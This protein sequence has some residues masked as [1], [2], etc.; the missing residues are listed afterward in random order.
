MT[1][2]IPNPLLAFI[3]LALIPLSPLFSVHHGIIVTFTGEA[4]TFTIGL[5]LILCAAW[6]RPPTYTHGI[7]Y[8]SLFAL[9]MVVLYGVQAVSLPFF[10]PSQYLIPMILFA[11]VGLACLGVE[12]LKAC[13]DPDK[14][15][16][17]LAIGLVIALCA[18]I[19]LGYMQ[20]FKLG[21][22]GGL[23][24]WINM[25]GV[26]GAF[27]Q[28]NQ[29]GNFM[30]CGCVALAYLYAT[31]KIN[32]ANFIGVVLLAAF[33]MAACQSRS[34]GLY[35]LAL[36]TYLAFLAFLW[37][38]KRNTSNKRFFTAI[39]AL[40]A[41]QVI[42]QLSYP[43]LNQKVVKPYILG[44]KPVATAMQSSKARAKPK[45]A[46]ARLTDPS[47]NAR[48]L[49]EWKK[50][51]L[52]FQQNPIIGAGAQ[53]NQQYSFFLQA[54]PQFSKVVEESLF[55]HSHNLFTQML[56]ETGLVGTGIILAWILFCLYQLAK[57]HATPRK[58]LAMG[59]L[60]V[61]LCHSMVEFPL[62]YAYFFGLL[63]ITTSLAIDKPI[64][65]PAPPKI[66]RLLL[67][68]LGVAGIGLLTISAIVMVVLSNMPSSTGGKNPAQDQQNLA[69][70]NRI[71]E[72]PLYT[73]YADAAR[74]SYITRDANLPI[75]LK[76][77]YLEQVT[78]FAAYGS[79]V[80]D[81]TRHLV[82]GQQTEKAIRMAKAWRGAYPRQA[83]RGLCAYYQEDNPLFATVAQGA[84]VEAQDC[85]A[86]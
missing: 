66:S 80:S 17:A 20:W 62:W 43:V 44:Q 78:Y 83:K 45:A 8:P 15:M 54:Q 37:L 60:L 35:I 47:A 55:T 56:S 86:R 41:L 32:L 38:F 79:R 48:R 1:N 85:E 26:F 65:L 21:H 3:L 7:P 28:K 14:L 29:Y 34:I 82:L 72:I 81:L 71:A 25:N 19:L 6:Y 16:T 42:G 39:V 74:Y 5:L 64:P 53:S 11:W 23:H 13:I 61:V 2:R 36:G 63:I 46:I 75:G 57:G 40:I 31:H 50:A 27:A 49:V 30:M 24:Y 73:A 10:Y 67:L 76:I 12:R 69:K 84:G 52:V 18:N 4:A 51:W 59:I 58:M 68:G 22:L 77:A 70:I 33:P 9:A